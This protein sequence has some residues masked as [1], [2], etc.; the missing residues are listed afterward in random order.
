L[1]RR[2]VGAGGVPPLPVLPVA[3]GGGVVRP[4]AA[5]CMRKLGREGEMAFA[6]LPPF[7]GLGGEWLGG[8]GVR[9]RMVPAGAVTVIGGPAGGIGEEAVGG[10]G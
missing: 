2:I 10:Y 9:G 3:V 5:V 6:F 1:L 7:C 8:G 4:A